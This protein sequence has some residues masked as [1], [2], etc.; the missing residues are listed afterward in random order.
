MTE[1]AFPDRAR[2]V[3]RRR[4]KA[5]DDEDHGDGEEKHFLIERIT[6]NLGLAQSIIRPLLR[7]ARFNLLF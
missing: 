7:A 3:L 1:T 2:D 6:L 4:P 5:D